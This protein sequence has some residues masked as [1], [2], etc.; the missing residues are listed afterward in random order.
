MTNKR[1]LIVG[2]GLSGATLAERLTSTGHTVLV[3]EK[4]DHIGGNCYDCIDPETQIRISK[5]GPHF[6]HTNDE[7]VWTYVNRFSEWVR[8][9]HKTIAQIGETYVP[10]PVNAETI[11]TL[12]RT[13]LQ[14]PED[15]RAWLATKQLTLERDPVNS[16]EVALQ[17]VGQ[18][19][20]EQIFK[21][22]TIKQWAKEP[23]ALEPSVLARIPVRE[24]YDGRYFTDRFQALPRN[25][26]TAMFEAML[27][28]IEVRLNTA[29]EDLSAEELATFDTVMFTGR[30][31]S[32]FK[33]AGLPLLEYRSLQFHITR[34]M[35]HP[36]FV[37]RGAV[38]NTPSAEIPF[39]RSVEYKWLPGAG[40]G[41]HSI[42]IHETSCDCKEGQE[43]YYPVPSA[44]NTALYEQYKSLATSVASAAATQKTYFVGRLANYKYFNMDQAIRAALDAFEAHFF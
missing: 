13:H 12:F 3:I 17:R 36:G 10:V 33:D 20:Y 43:P 1:V 40:E 8:Y 7:A 18:E 27:G 4:R 2:A 29:Y 32:Y 11:N 15:V 6:F 26:Y 31:D 35:N 24:T 38:V 21:P 30:I 9:D 22:Y 5:Y 34:Y 41:R 37:Q 25:G 16:E 44:A 19:L 39:T 42:V 14:T 23:A 28:G